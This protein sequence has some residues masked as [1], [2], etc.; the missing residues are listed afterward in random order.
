MRCVVQFPTHSDKESAPA[1][2]QAQTESEAGRVLRDKR[3]RKKNLRQS[4]PQTANEPD[5]QRTSRDQAANPPRA[6]S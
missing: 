1:T 5:A 4:Q 6:K 3:K 2:T